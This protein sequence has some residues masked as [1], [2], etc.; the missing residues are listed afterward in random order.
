MFVSYEC[1]S[2][3]TEHSRRFRDKKKKKDPEVTETVLK[4][5]ERYCPQCRE[6]VPLKI[7]TEREMLG[8]LVRKYPSCPEC[9]T[10]LADESMD[11]NI[12]TFN[13]FSIYYNLFKLEEPR[14]CLGAAILLRHFKDYVPENEDFIEDFFEWKKWAVSTIVSNVVDTSS[15]AKIFFD[16]FLMDF[17]S[18]PRVKLNEM[19]KKHFKNIDFRLEL[20][21][22]FGYTEDVPPEKK[23]YQEKLEEVMANKTGVE[24][25]Q[26]ILPAVEMYKYDLVFTQRSEEDEE[27]EGEDEEDEDEDDEEEEVQKPVFERVLKEIEVNVADLQFKTRTTDLKK[28][29]GKEE[30][31]ATYHAVVVIDNESRIVYLYRAEGFVPKDESHISFESKRVLDNIIKTQ[32][33]VG[34]EAKDIFS[35]E[36]FTALPCNDICYIAHRLDKPYLAH[37]RFHD[38]VFG[39][40]ENRDFVTNPPVQEEGFSKPK[41]QDGM[42][43][44]ILNHE[45]EVKRY[46]RVGICEKCLGITRPFLKEKWECPECGGRD[47]GREYFCSNCMESIGTG[48]FLCNNCG[49]FLI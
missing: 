47:S 6:M 11:I 24:Q 21:G 12:S 41:P 19:I 37:Y 29:R 43:E 1:T 34:Q 16:R 49:E 39:P 15:A 45:E 42:V 27:E 17:K 20:L 2:C 36:F 18:D 14:L 28:K 7:T 31:V 35:P 30:T 33:D 26:V 32:A 3:E 40:G 38:I 4:T 48:D 13:E 8:L 23:E 44:I 22:F 9:D 10:D 25:P 46:K 5:Q